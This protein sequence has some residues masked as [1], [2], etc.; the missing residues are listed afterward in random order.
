MTESAPQPDAQPNSTQTDEITWLELFYDLVYVAAIIQLGTALSENHSWSGVAQ[1]AAA[2]ALLWWVWS[3]TAFL[4]NRLPTDNVPRRVLVFLQTFAI[5]NLAIVIGGAFGETSVSFA[6]TYAAARFV[7]VLLHLEVLRR[8]PDARAHL[9]RQS[10]G[11]SVGVALWVLSAFVP[12]P[13]R[14]ALWGLAVA[15]DLWTALTSSERWKDNGRRDLRLDLPRLSERYGQFTLI[16]IGESFIKTVD[17]LSAEG[18]SLEQLIFSALAFLF[19][20]C[21]W[22]TYFSNVAG[23]VIREGEGLAWAYL[24]LPLMLGIV[25]MGV[26][27]SE[28]V[29]LEFEAA[30]DPAYHALLYGALVLIFLTFT[31][32]DRVTKRSSAKQNARRSLHVG[33]VLAFA[34]VFLLGASLSA[35]W[36]VGLGSLVA[37]GVIVA[38]TLLGRKRTDEAR[39]QLERSRT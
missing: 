17:G 31:V 12:P 20:A 22:W 28:V 1:F 37:L 3:G 14:F 16:V 27:L 25:T 10:G 11:F 32:L 21:V 7:L 9:L 19:I 26:G 35:F 34:A 4:F 24:H 13:W 33:A 23:V 5:G 38:E 2:F 6:L 36:S 39:A 29:K 8:T 30:F 15:V 18:L